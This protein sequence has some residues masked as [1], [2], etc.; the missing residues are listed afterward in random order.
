LAIAAAWFSSS[1]FDKAGD[2]SIEGQ[3]FAGPTCDKAL[4]EIETALGQT[5]QRTM[6]PEHARRQSGAIRRR[7]TEQR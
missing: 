6:K 3:G 5:I 1:A 7:A 4:A 2:C